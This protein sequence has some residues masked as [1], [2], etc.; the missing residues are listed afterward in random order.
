MGGRKGSRGAISPS[1]SET[2]RH[3]LAHAMTRGTFLKFG[4]LGI[5][6]ALGLIYNIIILRMLPPAVAGLFQIVNNF[7][8]IV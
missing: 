6:K 2:E 3:E 7:V 1:A 5:V 8:G 4:S